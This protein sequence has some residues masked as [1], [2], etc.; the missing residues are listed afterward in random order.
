MNKPGIEGFSGRELKIGVN[1]LNCLSQN[2][3]RDGSQ[4]WLKTYGKA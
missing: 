4:P 2:E 3:T 1:R